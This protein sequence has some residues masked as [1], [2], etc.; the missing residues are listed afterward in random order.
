MIP[1]F[2][3]KRENERGGGERKRANEEP[4]ISKVFKRGDQP[5]LKLFGQE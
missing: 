1:S 4:L 3:N 5:R 2:N